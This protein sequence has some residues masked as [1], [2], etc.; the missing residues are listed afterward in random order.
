MSSLGEFSLLRLGY[1]VEK[2]DPLRPLVGIETPPS[3][4]E[5]WSLWME[6]SV[7]LMTLLALYVSGGI[8]SSPE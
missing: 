7:S 4:F 1:G 2:E 5:G 6:G 8:S 3:G